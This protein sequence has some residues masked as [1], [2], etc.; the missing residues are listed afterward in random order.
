MDQKEMNPQEGQQGANPEPASKNPMGESKGGV[1]KVLLIVGIVLLVVFILAAIAFFV[2]FNTVKNSIE[3]EMDSQEQV[4]A[5]D[6]DFSDFGDDEQTETLERDLQIASVLA[7]YQ[8]VVDA[9]AEDVSWEGYLTELDQF[10]IEMEALVE[11]DEDPRLVDALELFA[12]ARDLYYEAVQ[13]DDPDA[14]IDEEQVEEA[15]DIISQAQDLV[16]EY[17]D[18]IDY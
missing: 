18:D 17:L 8:A 4:T 9:T 13:L 14:P 6:F 3:S 5:D 7:Q 16:N 12:E 11:I 10:I 15:G 2:I 1:N